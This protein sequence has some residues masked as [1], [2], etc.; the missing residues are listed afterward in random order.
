MQ[1]LTVDTVDTVEVAQRGDDDELIRLQRLRA[2]QGDVE[3][4]WAMGDLYYWGARGLPRDQVQ[5]RDYFGRAADAGHMP[6][7][8]R[9]G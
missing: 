6:S 7:I 4:M 3:A 1:R 8:V 2:E 9:R 5:A